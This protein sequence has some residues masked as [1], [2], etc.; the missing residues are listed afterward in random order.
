[1]RHFGVI[2]GAI[3][4]A[5]VMSVQVVA[6]EAGDMYNAIKNKSEAALKIAKAGKTDDQV[7][8]ETMKAFTGVIDQCDEYAKRFANGANIKDVTYEKAKAYF[9]L[10]QLQEPQKQKELEDKAAETA[11]HAIE[12]DPKADAAARARG[13]LLQYYRMNK[14]TEEA[15]KQAQAI[16]ADFPNSSFAAFA[17]LYIGDTYEKTGKEAEALA[18]YEKLVKT[19]PDDP[20]GVRAAG[21]LAFKKLPGSLLDLH[22]TSTD[23][24]TI[25]LKDYRGKVVLVDFWASWCPPCRA[26][27]PALV[28]TEKSLRAK[29]FQVLG[30]SLDGDKD[31][32]NKFIKDTHMSWPQYFD[33]KEWDN[34]IVRKYGII[35]IPVTLL[36]DKAG[37]VREV[38]LRDHELQAAIQKLLDEKAP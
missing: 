1:M 7:R 30:I 26:S 4:V 5:S 14:N 10:A 20:A 2:L 31:A 9:F 6:D 15:L 23:G 35:S 22:F 27:L 29:G 16:V 36:V 8:D 17:L 11:R 32:M 3:V 13:L 34:A 19:Y 28:E 18:A 12:L 38:G 33:G 24:K 37:K 25:D 21:I